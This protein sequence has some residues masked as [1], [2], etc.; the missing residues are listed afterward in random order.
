MIL[1]FATAVNL[2]HLSKADVCYGDGTFKVCPKLLY[3]LYT[4]HT[5]VHGQILPLVFS[6]LPSKSKK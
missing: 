4:I 3:Q 5:E 2:H 1:M 6:L